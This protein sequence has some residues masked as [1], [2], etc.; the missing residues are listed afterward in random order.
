MSRV[1]C[2]SCNKKKFKYF[3]HKDTDICE[4]CYAENKHLHFRHNCVFTTQLN[5]KKNGLYYEVE[6]TSG[7]IGLYERLIDDSICYGST[8]QHDYQFT[9]IN[10]K[11]I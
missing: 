7:L 6:M 4:K 10:Y 11:D 2:E 1:V 9:F 5:Y 3:M 8:G